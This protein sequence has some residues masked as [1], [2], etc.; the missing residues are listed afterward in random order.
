MQTR[1]ITDDLMQ[2]E[3]DYWQAIREGDIDAALALADDPCIVAGSSGVASLDHATFERMMRAAT[4]R[5]KD[6]VI[7]DVQSREVSD[8][9]VLLAYKVRESLTVDGKPVSFDAA[10]TSVWVRKGDRWAC[11][12]HTESILGDSF[13]RDR[14]Q[15]GGSS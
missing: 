4:Y 8:D 9:L 6:V 1:T 3:K 15:P 14:V 2:L 7:S 10:D 13:G 12:L 5:I 11:V